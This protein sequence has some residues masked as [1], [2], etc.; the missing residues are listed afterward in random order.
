MQVD[1]LKYSSALGIRLKSHCGRDI[2]FDGRIRDDRATKTESTISY[3]GIACVDRQ[4][5][6]Q[7]GEYPILGQLQ[8]NAKFKIQISFHYITALNENKTR[9]NSDKHCTV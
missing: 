1:R 5:S 3:C 9:V 8:K 7:Q 4:N 2:R 6:G